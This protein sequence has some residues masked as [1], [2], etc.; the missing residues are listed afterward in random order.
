MDST[1]QLGA[2]R[3][4]PQLTL[5]PSRH[6]TVH[7]LSAGGQMLMSLMVINRAMVLSKSVARP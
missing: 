7:D 5:T 3:L 6:S 2:A 4:N 1:L